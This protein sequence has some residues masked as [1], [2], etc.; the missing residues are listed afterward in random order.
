MEMRKEL[1]H[2][3]LLVYVGHIPLNDEI[4]Y[5]AR[6]KRAENV[7]ENMNRSMYQVVGE[8]WNSVA[9]EMAA[10]P[11]LHAL[12]STPWR[13]LA[14]EE[15]CIC[16]AFRDNSVSMLPNHSTS[17]APEKYDP[18]MECYRE[19]YSRICHV[20]RIASDFEALGTSD[21]VE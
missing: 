19:L 6:K 8:W 16:C 13:I 20:S 1:S 21:Y 3:V 18:V 14:S 12:V 11:M 10:G 4:M 2:A 17:M 7:I 5:C 9:V 15:H